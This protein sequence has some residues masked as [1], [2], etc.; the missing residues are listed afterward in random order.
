MLRDGDIIHA[1]L[2][3]ALLTANSVCAWDLNLKTH[4]KHCRD[5]M[6]W[7]CPYLRCTDK[8][9]AEAIGHHVAGLSVASITNLGVLLQTVESTTEASVNTMRLSPARLHIEEA[10]VS[11]KVDWSW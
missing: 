2:G 5:S 4:D 8:E 3:V 1:R 11:R 7:A 10:A 6:D 9:L